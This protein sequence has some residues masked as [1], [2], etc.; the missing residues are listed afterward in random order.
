MRITKLLPYFFLVIIAIYS[1]QNKTNSSKKVRDTV[2]V[3]NVNTNLNLDAKLILDMPQKA[4]CGDIVKYSLK[5][6]QAISPDSIVLLLDNKRYSIIKKL[7]HENELN[8]KNMNVGTH[9]ISAIVYLKDKNKIFSNKFVLLSDIVPQA[10]TYKV[11]KIYHHDPH[12][13]TQ[14]LCINNGILYESTGLKS[15]STLRRVDLKTGKVEY[16]ITIPNNFFGE[17]ITV[18]GNNVYQITWQNHTGFIYEKNNFQKIGQFSYSTEGWGLTNNNKYLFMSDG[19]NRIFVLDPTTLS[20][21]REIQVYDNKGPIYYL[22]ELEYINGVI[23]ANVY[24][25]DFIV[26]IDPK[27]GKVLTKIDFSNILSAGLKTPQTDVLN[28]IAYDKET[29]KIYVTGKN[30]PELFEV[31]IVNK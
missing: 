7:N 28:G 5:T 3:Q 24:T 14:G 16:S 27:T 26:T 21:V 20:V 12:A 19:T 30:W 22:N 29:K 11:E 31:K 9:S 25:K 6:K 13:Y 23:Y 2:P 8:T 15:E 17:G 18:F 4:K 10:Q 1:C